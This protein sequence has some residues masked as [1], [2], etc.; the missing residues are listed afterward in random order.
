MDHLNRDALMKLNRLAMPDCSD[1][2]RRIKMN[3]ISSS[4]LAKRKLIKNS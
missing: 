3:K 1:A 2:G 4:S